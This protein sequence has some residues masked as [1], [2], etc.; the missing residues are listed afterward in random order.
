VPPVLRTPFTPGH[1]TRQA[2]PAPAADPPASEKNP[3]KRPAKP[4]KAPVRPR[5]TGIVTTGPHSMA[6]IARGSQT[7]TLAPGETRGTVTLLEIRD[8]SVRV[9][10]ENGEYQLFLPGREEENSQ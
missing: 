6:L 7:M 1:E 8:G 3:E 4:R 5:L 2:P 9:R 10:D